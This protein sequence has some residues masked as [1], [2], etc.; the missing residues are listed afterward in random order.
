MDA[1]LEWAR[2]PFFYFALA[3][4]VLGLARHVALTIWEL[5]RNIERSGDRRLTWSAIARA[6]LK[7]LF[8]V[9]KVNNKPGYS[10]TT[11][12]FHVS[13]LVVPIFF[14]GHIVLIERGIGFS[15]PAL[16]NSLAD[17]LTCVVVATAVILVVLRATDRTRRALSRFQDYALP[18]VV[19]APFLTGLLLRHATINPLSFEA[20]YLLHVVSA[21]I[22]LIL[23][24]ITKLSH[25]ALMP[26][27]QLIAEAG[28]RF[29][30]RVGS[31]VAAALGK[32]NEPV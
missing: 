23:I 21:N 3:F 20:M 7:W 14:A 4:M 32:E 10:A 15:W 13:L 25:C 17:L 24:P 1:W 16:P 30:P 29:P 9:T 5:A 18:L 28:W 6:Q 2:G 26:T 31:R 22:V 19:A 8:P 11:V 27:N 12:A